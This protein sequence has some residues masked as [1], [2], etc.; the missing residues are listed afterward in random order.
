[1]TEELYILQL[2]LLGNWD[3]L[4]SYL[5]LD[6][7]EST[8]LVR[9]VDERQIQRAH[10]VLHYPLHILIELIILVLNVVICYILPK[11]VLVERAREV[12]VQHVTVKQRLHV[13]TQA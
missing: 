9:L 1:M 4:A 13:H 10:I 11:H 7:L 12:R 2:I 3:M 8:E 6:L 5:Q